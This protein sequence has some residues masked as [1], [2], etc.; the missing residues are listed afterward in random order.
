MNSLCTDPAI[1]RLR[2]IDSAFL[3]LRYIQIRFNISIWNPWADATCEAK[4]AK[5]NYFIWRAWVIVLL[6]PRTLECCFGWI[7]RSWKV[8]KPS[9]HKTQHTVEPFTC[10]QFDM[11]DV[12]NILFIQGNL[13]I[14]GITV[15]MNGLFLLTP[16]TFARGFDSGLCCES[17]SQTSKATLHSFWSFDGIM[18]V[19]WGFQFQGQVN[20]IKSC[21]QWI[22]QSTVFP[23]CTA[24]QRGFWWVKWQE[25]IQMWILFPALVRQT[26][27]AGKVLSSTLKKKTFF[28]CAS[29]HFLDR[30]FGHG[31]VI[32][33]AADFYLF[34]TNSKM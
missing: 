1:L 34:M 29:Q 9:D 23:V 8:E 18:L 14:Q 26:L 13:C 12:Y 33:I 20:C 5:C 15:C 19:M 7:H 4:R 11:R 10:Q 16:P 6:R 3:S 28:L 22:T 30:F 31:H 27:C 32:N 24:V 25:T 17:F 2:R 21:V